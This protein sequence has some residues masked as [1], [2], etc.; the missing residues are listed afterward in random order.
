MKKVLVIHYSQSGQLTEILDNILAPI[1]SESDVEI[2]HL[3]IEM[4]SPFPFPWTKK[5]FFGVF[6]E[7]FL[8][9]PQPIKAI[10]KEILEK[11]YDL[12]IFGYTIWYLTPSLPTTSFLA[13]PDAQKLLSN[14]KVITVIGCRNMWIMAHEKLKR[15]LKDFNAELVGNI[16]LADRHINHISVITI[17][18]WMFSGKKYKYLNIFPKP[19][20]SQKDI[21]ESKK[22]G[23]IIL[24]HLKQDN[25]N[26]LQPQLLKKEA[27]KIKPFLITTDKKANRIF[28]KWATLIGSNTKNRTFLLKLFN[29]YLIFA[30]WVISPVVFI[31]F[32]ATYL[33]RINKIKKDKKYYSSVS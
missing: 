25:Y 22:F 16:V 21:D 15:R 18:K 6:P 8:Q 20:V 29:Y 4:E 1:N 33:L 5:E 14:K 26:T 24:N 28:S 3:A 2:D 12:I 31:L 9:K 7:T 27:V 19:G 10:P 11:N 32:L 23:P 17:T 30:I 13:S